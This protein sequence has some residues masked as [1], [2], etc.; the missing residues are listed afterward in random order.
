[1][2]GTYSKIKS[3]Q[4]KAGPLKK[5]LYRACP[6]WYWAVPNYGMDFM[7]DVESIERCKLC[8]KF[9]VHARVPEPHPGKDKGE[10]VDAMNYP[11]YELIV[12]EWLPYGEMGP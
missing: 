7:M 4:S 8:G 9:K 10:L 12:D 1:M 5:L 6:H 11:G 3:K 2:R